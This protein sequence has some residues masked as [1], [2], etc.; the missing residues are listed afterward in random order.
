MDDARA[1]MRALMGESSHLDL[2]ALMDRVDQAIEGQPVGLALLA[3]SSMAGKL[4]GQHLGPPR[5]DVGVALSLSIQLAWKEIA[6]SSA[7][8]EVMGHA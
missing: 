2:A 1:V 4:A 5:R 8:P 3:M 7:K 6:T